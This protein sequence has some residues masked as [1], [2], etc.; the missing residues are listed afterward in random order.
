MVRGNGGNCS[1]YVLGSRKVL[2]QDAGSSTY[3]VA[4]N[5]TDSSGWQLT[6]LQ[7]VSEWVMS[8]W[9]SG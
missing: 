5:A 3:V 8:E 1:T 7:C 9:V 4:L 2:G 6:A